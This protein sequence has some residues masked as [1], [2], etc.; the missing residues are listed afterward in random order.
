MS[1]ELL[2]SELFA[3]TLA[4]L[5]DLTAL[6]S[7][8]VDSD[9]LARVAAF[10]REALEAR[11]LSVEIEPRSGVEGGPTLPVLHARGPAAGEGLGCLLLLGHMDTV[12]S[13]IPPKRQEGRLLA[14][15]AIDMKGG[16]ATFVGALDL[17]ARRR[18]APPADLHLVVV[19]DEEVGG[20]LS[21]E[22]TAR[23]GALARAVWVL[24]PG[25]P[26]GASETMVAGRRGMR[27]WRLIASGT[28]AHSGLHYW[29]G[30]S[31]LIAAARWCAA[32]EALSA[33]GGGPTIN[34]GRLIAG[35]AGFVSD[36]AGNAG[37]LGTESRLNVVPDHAIAEGEFR[38][39][40]AA[41]GEKIA[42]ELTAL[43]RSIGEESGTHLDLSI[44]HAVPPVDP[45]GPQRSWC[46][47]AVALAASRGWTLE[48]E[49]DR[50]GISFPNFLPDPVRVP[51][52]DGLGPVGGG[53]H[54]REEF[55]D[56][57][58][59]ARRIALLADLFEA[60][61]ATV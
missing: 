15:G 52:L 53:M 6:S 5:S 21:R 49:D 47:R 33:R 23:W 56:L 20:E 39:L 54:T 16:L 41:E 32:A 42:A 37:L 59:L 29:Q 46:E 35:D 51:V 57:T 34:V 25:E 4:F 7:P 14:T 10:L 50:G 9:G 13:A 31:A 30:H 26:R 24:E 43:A 3:S 27:N 1:D 19:P 11:G 40:R 17:L 22:A 55:L 8:S 2:P 44:G 38:F 18:I 12:L 45:H 58:S 28:P 48:V 61:A 60:D 36:P